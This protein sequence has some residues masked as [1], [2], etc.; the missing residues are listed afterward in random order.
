M[1]K[2]IVFKSP[3]QYVFSYVCC[4]YII[5]FKDMMSRNHTL[6]NIK[7]K[8]SRYKN[9]NYSIISK[10][11]YKSTRKQLKYNSNFCAGY[12]FLN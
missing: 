7:H 9:R 2:V 6:N 12:V 1:S 10:F 5:Y 4:F 11:I 3:I 8:F